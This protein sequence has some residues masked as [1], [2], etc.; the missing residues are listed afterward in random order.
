MSRVEPTVEKIHQAFDANPFPGARWLVG[1]T[2]GTEPLDVVGPFQAIE[3]WRELDAAFLDAHAEALS[4]FSEAGFRFYL[5]AYLIADMRAELER[6]DP[7][8]HLTHGFTDR[9]VH[10]DIGGESIERAI[11]GNALVNPKRYGAMRMEDATRYRLSIFTREECSAIVAYLETVRARD[12]FRAASIDTALGSF[13]RPRAST[14]P[15]A[16]DLAQ[17]EAMLARF[18]AAAQREAPDD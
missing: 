12:A 5:P 15:A 8:F 9:T 2:D 14:A 7:V 13:W 18:L 3:S 4:F 17:N 6:A 1:S 16:A 10:I 11:G